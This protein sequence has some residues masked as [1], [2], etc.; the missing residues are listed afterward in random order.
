MTD[1]TQS[2]MP[3]DLSA[4]PVRD[5][6]LGQ[7]LRAVDEE[8]RVE[9]SDLFLRRVTTTSTAALRR[10][11]S[12]RWWQSTAQT[13]RFAI[14]LGLAAAA[15]ALFTLTRVPPRVPMGDAHL[16]AAIGVASPSEAALWSVSGQDRALISV[17]GE[18]SR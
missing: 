3:D 13:G 1:M 15:A 16:L 7:W 10:Q 14:P 18:V 2:D 8:R 12:V 17:F 6:S 4:E 5:A 9:T 11:R